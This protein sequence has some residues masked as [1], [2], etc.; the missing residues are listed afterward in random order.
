MSLHRIELNILKCKQG[1]SKALTASSFSCDFWK[2]S[3]WTTRNVG[4]KKKRFPSTFLNLG[5][6]FSIRKIGRKLQ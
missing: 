1:K 4:E 3:P 6:F 5:D 2:K